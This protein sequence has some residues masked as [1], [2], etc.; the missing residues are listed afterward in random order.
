LFVSLAFLQI[1]IDWLHTNP[2]IYKNLN[3]LVAT[4]VSNKTLESGI[5]KIG[6][7][8]SEFVSLTGYDSSQSTVFEPTSYTVSDKFF[9]TQGKGSELFDVLVKV[10]DIYLNGLNQNTHKKE[11]EKLFSADLSNGLLEG[12]LNIWLDWKFAHVPATVARLFLSDYK[13]RLNLLAGN[14]DLSEEVKREGSMVKWAINLDDVLFGDTATFVVSKNNTA[15]F[16]LKYR[17][18]SV[19]EF[20]ISNDT[21]YFTPTKT[22]EYYLSFGSKVGRSEQLKISVKPSGFIRKNDNGIHFF[23]VGKQTELEVRNFT[24]VSSIRGEG[25]LKDVTL[26][27]GK[28]SFVPVRSGWCNIKLLNDAGNILMED[29][30]FVQPIPKPTILATYANGNKLSK[31]QIMK[32]KGINLSATHPLKQNFDYT[33]ESIKYGIIGKGYQNKEIKGAVIPISQSE[34]ESALYVEIIELQISIGRNQIKVTD[35]LIIELI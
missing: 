16:S 20:Y 12:N 24:N 9:I 19:R 32:G 33:I 4:D 30:I 1:P 27:N 15:E 13:M 17:G 3:S 26:K 28:F 23:Y 14:V 31:L 8:D 7:L 18:T 25:L 2:K 21:I 10:K 6:K 5:H 35:P 22:G 11:F 34:L 29:S